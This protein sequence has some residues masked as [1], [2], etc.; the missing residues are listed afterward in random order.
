MTVRQ[1]RKYLVATVL[2]ECLHMQ[3]KKWL[4]VLTHNDGPSPT[5]LPLLASQSPT[6]CSRVKVEV[7]F[8]VAAQMQECSILID[9][10]ALVSEDLAILVICPLWVWKT[11][12]CE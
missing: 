2:A 8:R 3:W 6:Q 7:G 12:S 10:R 1:K 11:T 9:E 5:V 4:L